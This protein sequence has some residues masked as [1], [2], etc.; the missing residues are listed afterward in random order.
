MVHPGTSVA[1]S[2]VARWL[3]ETLQPDLFQDYAPNGLQV[4]GRPDIRHVLT[5]VTASRALIDEA[6]RRGADTLLVHHG[7]FWK[8][9]D[10][11]I[12][13]A[14]RARIARVLEH[15]LNLF[16]YHLP[17]DAHPVLGNNARLAHMLDFTPLRDADGRPRTCGPANLMWLGE[18]APRSLAEL[19]DHISARLGRTA[20]AL[21]DPQR[22]ITRLAWCTGGAQSMMDVAIA[23]G[24]DAF[25][26]GEASE[27]NFHQAQESG[28]AFIAAGHHATERYGALALG[29]A[30]KQEFD[31]QV[32]FVDL[33]NPV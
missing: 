26:T 7:W 25:I 8:N 2:D 17:L 1:R 4:E 12:C 20:L 32:D 15:G 21:G 13:G 28:T 19:A 5:G 9:E 31:I 24:V 27:Q 30:L 10:S 18:C 14:R 23:Q 11:R 33:F 3:D 22:R 16:A 29:Q 6:I